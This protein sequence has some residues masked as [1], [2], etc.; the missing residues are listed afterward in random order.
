M[1]KTLYCCL[2]FFLL[3]GVLIAQNQFTVR[4]SNVAAT[5][6]QVVVLDPIVVETTSVFIPPSNALMVLLF[7]P[8]TK[9]SLMTVSPVWSGVTSLSCQFIDNQIACP[10]PQVP[11]PMKL[12]FTVALDLS[13][14]AFSKDDVGYV[15]VHV[16]N[17]PALVINPNVPVFVVT[18]GPIKPPGVAEKARFPFVVDSLSNKTGIFIRNLGTEPAKVICDMVDYSGKKWTADEMTLQPGEGA[19]FQIGD[20]KKDWRGSMV[21]SSDQPIESVAFVCDG[22]FKLCVPYH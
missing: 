5:A 2:I 20:Y 22:D 11:T 3:T 16:F 6:G 8:L 17:T 19:Q 4:A 12:T 13:Q 9:V 1:K 10:L 7:P 15:G 21:L 18:E 14:A